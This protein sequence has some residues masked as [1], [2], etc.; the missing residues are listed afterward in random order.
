MKI[1]HWSGYGTIN[2]VKKSKRKVDSWF[3]VNEYCDGTIGCECNNCD[4]EIVDN[5]WI[6]WHE[7]YSEEI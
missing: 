6:E 2:I 4:V 7:E 5:G 1:K 3:R